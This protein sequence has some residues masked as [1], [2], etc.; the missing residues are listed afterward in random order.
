MAGKRSFTQLEHE[1]RAELR[2]KINEADDQIDIEK[3]FAY[4][5][6]KLL[7]RALDRKVDILYD[8]IVYDG[9]SPRH[10]SLSP[11]IREMHEFI[12]VYDNSDL[13]DILARMAESA[14]NARQQLNRITAQRTRRL[15]G[16]PGARYRTKSGKRIAVSPFSSKMR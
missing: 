9:A 2:D 8:D 14:F 5:M 15:R 10:Y 16:A 12:E 13:P 1:F 4:V 6:G 3:Q 7:W 11:R